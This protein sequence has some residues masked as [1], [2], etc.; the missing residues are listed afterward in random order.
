MTI[1]EMVKKQMTASPT[2]FTNEVLPADADSVEQ[3]VNPENLVTGH[4]KYQLMDLGSS[5]NIDA[6]TLNSYLNG[7]GVLSGH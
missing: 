7:K 1:D 3:Y 4:D 6:S 5:N 2:I